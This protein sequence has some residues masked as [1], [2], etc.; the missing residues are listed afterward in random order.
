MSESSRAQDTQ[1]F[2]G[3]FGLPPDADFSSH[4]IIIGCMS[5]FALFMV[6]ARIWV[7]WS[8]HQIIKLGWDDA[9][10]VV[11]WIAALP[12]AVVSGFLTDIGIGRDIWD[13]P[14]D[15]LD[16]FYLFFFYVEDISYSI[17][18]GKWHFR[19]S[20][21]APSGSDRWATCASQI[22]LLL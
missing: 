4:S 15:N 10:L 13:Y 3:P 20:V 8:G 7:R 22:L 16:D 14:L 6:I 21:V 11:C 12:I 18:T 17:E 5:A 1:H 9:M 2:L 19:Y